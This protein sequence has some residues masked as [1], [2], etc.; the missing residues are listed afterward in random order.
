M[1]MSFHLHPLMLTFTI[2]VN[3]EIEWDNPV[4]RM[5]LKAGN[6]LGS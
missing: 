2:Q 5:P 6:R 3:V 1:Y 4:K